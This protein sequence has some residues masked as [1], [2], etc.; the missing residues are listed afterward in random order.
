MVH[1]A[2]ITIETNGFSDIHDITER[3]ARVIRDSG[4]GNGSVSTGLNIT[5]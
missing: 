3:V 5:E 2:D 1:G 4:A